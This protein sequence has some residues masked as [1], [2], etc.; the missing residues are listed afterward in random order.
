[1][2]KIDRV[3][4][5]VG[6]ECNLNC[7]YC[8]RNLN[9]DTNWDY[10]YL[11]ARMIEYLHNLDSRYIKAVIVN[12]GEPLLYLERVKRVFHEV[13]QSIHKK[14][15]TNATLLTD[16][17]VEYLNK[18]KI[19]V[20]LSHDG[21]VTEYTRGVDILKSDHYVN[22]IKKIEN[23]SISAVCTNLNTD[24]L[25][26]YDYVQNKLKRDIFIT[27]NPVFENGANDFLVKDFNYREYFDSNERLFTSGLM[28][29]PKFCKSSY[30]L[31]KKLNCVNFTMNGE[32]I[33]AITTAYLGEISD[34][35]ELIEQTTDQESPL[36]TKD[37]DIKEECFLRKTVASD[38][39]CAIEHNILKH[40]RNKM[41]T[42]SSYFS[43]LNI[44]TVFLMLGNKC[45]FSCR[46]CIQEP[47]NDNFNLELS[48]KCKEYLMFLANLKPRGQKLRIQFWGGEP[49]LYFDFIEQFVQQ[50][51]DY[52][53][54]AYSIITNG[55]LLNA[56]M[57]EFFNEHDVSVAL[58]NDGP[59]TDRIRGVN[60]L[61]DKVFVDLFMKLKYKSINTVLTAINQDLYANWQY[62]D[63]KCPDVYNNIELLIHSWDYP[64]D[65]FDFDLEQFKNQ[66]EKIVVKAK[67]D[68]VNGVWSRELEFLNIY[69]NRIIDVVKKTDRKLEQIANCGQVTNVM[70]LD[71]EGNI[72]QCHNNNT[73]IG[74]TDDYY[75]DILKRYTDSLQV[76]FNYCQNCEFLSICSGGCPIELLDAT[77][78]K[79]CEIRK[80]LISYAIQYILSF[81]EMP[82]FLQTELKY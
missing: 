76:V 53:R 74:N 32:L 63:E 40:R 15:I 38:H 13:P 5:Y 39:M 71:L 82:E 77:R 28:R 45:N 62:F 17:I 52:D 60:V 48:D 24:V 26:I 4:V 25:K 66:L 49:L 34:S 72:Y 55:S 2:Y 56:E 7:L 14:I 21:E 22:L 68:T 1:M 75:E 33:N 51:K 58:S 50:F 41:Q 23:L 64:N 70:N 80:T 73:I 54:F 8:M 67:E 44:H 16:E 65:I 42:A 29:V 10:E 20:S 61:E 46:H 9:T 11:S 19:E 3:C 59:H 18:N 12:G 37:C 78:E 35:N 43:E 36:C 57:V 47:Q 6:K 31:R 69:R 81:N 79:F 27:F 30:R